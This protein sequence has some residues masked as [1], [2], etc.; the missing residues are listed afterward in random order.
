MLGLRAAC[1][2]AHTGSRYGFKRKLAYA[3][4]A[5]QR[6]TCSVHDVSQEARDHDGN[7]PLWWAAAH[8]RTDMV[9]LLAAAGA[10]REA[11]DQKVGER[12]ERGRVEAVQSMS[13][14]MLLT[15]W[16]GEAGAP[17]GAPTGR[18]GARR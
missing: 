10:D 2:A 3:F 14:E 12:E 16:R 17:T 1:H 13:A 6:L 9:R 5:T 7:T 15:L 4:F 8:G 18:H 11:R